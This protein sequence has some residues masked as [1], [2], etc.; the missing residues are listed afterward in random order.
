[1]ADPTAP[2]SRPPAAEVGPVPS[3]RSAEAGAARGPPP[4]QAPIPRLLSQARRPAR[5]MQEVPYS[6]DSPINRVAGGPRPWGAW[7]TAAAEASG[8]GCAG[9]PIGDQMLK[10]VRRTSRRSGKERID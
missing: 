10:T 3:T 6:I 4:V 1:M 7:D 5:G 8:C 9:L 2:P